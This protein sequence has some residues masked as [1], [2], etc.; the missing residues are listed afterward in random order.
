MH[1]P[2]QMQAV[3]PPIIPVIGELIRQH[4]GT[5][6]LGQGVVSYGPPPEAIAQI[7][8][9]LANPDFHK[10]QAVQGIPPLVEQSAAKLRIENGIEIG[11]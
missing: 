4:P 5:I 10:Y 6:S 9:F 2:T 1:Q 11:E 3:Q 7:S 8:Q